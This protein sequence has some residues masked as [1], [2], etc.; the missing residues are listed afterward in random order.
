MK[1]ADLKQISA[2][3]E[4]LF[5]K[6]MEVTLQDS[7]S[8][9]YLITLPFTSRTG[10]PFYIWAFRHA[11]SRKLQLSDGALMT[12]ELAKAGTVQLE[13]IQLL[14]NSYGLSLMED[15]SVM[16][17]SNRPLHKRIASFLQVL[18]AIDGVLRMWTSIKEKP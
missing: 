6:S 15:R 12:K 11:G 2:S 9:I 1:P 5:Q 4:K 3:V 17:T 7:A 8:G 13:A 18:V 10:H 16:E 14:V